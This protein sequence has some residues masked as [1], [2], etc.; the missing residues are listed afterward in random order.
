MDYNLQNS[1]SSQGNKVVY[2]SQAHLEKP[3]KD[4]TEHLQLL[5]QHR[6]T[7]KNDTN[8]GTDYYDEG[9]NN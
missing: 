5:N 8:N 2:E 4:R 1:S 3:R 9:T 7:Q 6:F